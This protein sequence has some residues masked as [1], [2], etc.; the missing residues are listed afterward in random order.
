MVGNYNDCQPDSIIDRRAIFRDSNTGMGYKN[1]D[2]LI[3]A[4]IYLLDLALR[5]NRKHN[6]DA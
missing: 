2:A 3:R 6:V 4:G 5:A 1:R